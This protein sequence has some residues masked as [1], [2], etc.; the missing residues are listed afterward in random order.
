MSSG[1]DYGPL[2]PHGVGTLMKEA[3][4]RAMV[5][6]RRER[7]TFEAK[8][9]GTSANGSPDF[10]TTADRAAQDVFVHLLQEWFPGYGIVAEEDRLHLPCTLKGHDAWFTID[11][12]DGTKAFMRRQ[13]HGIGTMLS[14]V[15]D[16]Q[17]VAA[18]VGDVMTQEVYATR[19]E[20]SQVF[21]I[22]EFGIA[23]ELKA[24]VDRALS[25]QWLLMV[26]RPERCSVAA[27]ALI[28]DEGAFN[29]YEI[30]TGSIGI[31]FARLWK[32][33][34]G[35]LLLRPVHM[36]PWDFAPL[37]CM[38]L[39]LGYHFLTVDPEGGPTRDYVHR[40]IPALQPVTHET[41]VVHRSRLPELRAWLDG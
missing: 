7:F 14:L 36:T 17:V 20:S 6:I 40:I 10:V 24:D 35:G 27:R 12:L 29:G 33:E 13:S 5:A 25:Q 23:E 30:T 34:V 22:S 15:I 32:G 4:R 18:V 11:P 9:K 37:L 3:V 28:A 21:R 31:G 41:L 8:V 19:P 39:R 26:Q 2:T 1:T 16:G 38:S